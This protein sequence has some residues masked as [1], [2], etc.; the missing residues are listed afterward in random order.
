MFVRACVCPLGP[1]Y[2][3][4]QCASLQLVSQLSKVVANDDDQPI[5]PIQIVNCGVV[6]TQVQSAVFLLTGIV[7]FVVLV[8][9]VFSGQMRDHRIEV[10]VLNDTTPRNKCLSIFEFTLSRSFDRWQ[11]SSKPKKAK[12]IVELVF[13]DSIKEI[14]FDEACASIVGRYLYYKLPIQRARNDIK[15]SSMCRN[16]M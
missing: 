15:L 2:E 1:L 13:N 3:L 7:V 16:R 9:C 8:V 10:V 6:L 12:A 14:Q 4:L 11:P 5:L